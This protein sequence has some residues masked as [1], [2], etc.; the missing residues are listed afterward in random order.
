MRATNQSIGR[1]VRHVNDFACIL[2][3]DRR[4][5]APRIRSK[6]PRWIGEDVQIPGDFAGVAR[7]IAA[8]FREKREGLV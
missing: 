2:L 3:V 5:A 7:G 8:F 4:Y 6:L 1:A